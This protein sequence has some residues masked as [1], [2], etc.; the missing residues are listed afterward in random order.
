MSLYRVGKTWYIYLVHDGRRIRC[1]T[2][3]ERREAAQRAHDELKASLWQRPGDAGKTWRDAVAAWLAAAPRDDADKYRLRSL[4]YSD[5]PLSEVTA[6]SILSALADKSAS[7]HNRYLNLIGAIL[8]AARRRGWMDA[9]P[10]LERRKAD[11]KPFRWLTHEEWRRL[12]KELPEHLKPIASFAL[13]TGLRESNVLYLKWE[14]V[15]MRRKTVTIPADVAKGRKTLG[16]P[17]SEGAMAVLRA[18]RGKCDVWVFPY[19]SGPLTR[20]KRGWTD[21]CARSGIKCRFHDLRHTWASWHVQ[22]GTPLPVLKELG[23]WASYSM[24]LRYA[25]LAPEH[26]RKWVNV[27][28]NSRHI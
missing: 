13:A 22:S 21:A 28:G 18:Q 2:H 9:V 26:L 1:S 10:H 4:D 6:D 23:G 5:R 8:N 15:D 19:R 12:Y 20:I 27:S 25:H 7:T 17:L 14:Q 24:V 11:P 16:L 3:T